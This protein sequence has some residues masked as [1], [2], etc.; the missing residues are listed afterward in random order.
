[1]P[2]VGKS[3]GDAEFVGWVVPS[4]GAGEAIPLVGSKPADAETASTHVKAIAE[5]SR[6]MSGLLVRVG[7]ARFVTSK[8]NTPIS[9]RS[10]KVSR[11]QLVF[12]SYFASFLTFR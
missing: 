11:G 7:D 9:E 10:W 4:G 12:R 1:M 3:P 8:K 2:A 6:F 5:S